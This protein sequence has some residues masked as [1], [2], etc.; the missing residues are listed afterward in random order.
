MA[1]KFEE[2]VAVYKDSQ[3]TPTFLLPLLF[4]REKSPKATLYS[5]VVLV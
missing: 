3:P 2:P 4:P 1:V 5:P